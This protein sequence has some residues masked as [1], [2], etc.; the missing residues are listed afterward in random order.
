MKFCTL[1]DLTSVDLREMGRISLITPDGIFCKY[2]ISL[3]TKAYMYQ[4][5]RYV[6]T[7]FTM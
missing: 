6:F 5:L 2:P 7:R 3:I 4:I 1:Q